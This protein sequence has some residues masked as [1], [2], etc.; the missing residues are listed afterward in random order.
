[1]VQQGHWLFQ[2]GQASNDLQLELANWTSR[3][4]TN[5]PPWAAYWAIMASCLIT[6]NELAA[7]G[8]PHWLQRDHLLADGKDR[9]WNLQHSHNGSLWQHQPMCWSVGRH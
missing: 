2:F 5:S 8:P 9:H 7:K 3:L 1:M 4:A 6:I